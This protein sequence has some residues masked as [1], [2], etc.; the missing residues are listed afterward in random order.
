[1]IAFFMGL[2]VMYR[3][4]T[5]TELNF[6]ISRLQNEYSAIVNDNQSIKIAIENGTNLS[7]ISLAA[8]EKLGMQKPDKYQ[9]N[10]IRIPKTNYTVAGIIEEETEKTEGLFSRLAKLEV[11]ENFKR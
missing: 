6:R 5:I 4:T 1:M 8:S 11:L 2:F 3:Y 9:V 7:K 10:Y